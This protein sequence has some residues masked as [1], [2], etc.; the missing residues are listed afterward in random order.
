MKYLGISSNIFGINI[1]KDINKK[2]LFLSQETQL[3]K[4]LDMFGILKTKLV[5]LP[6]SQLFKLRHDQ[7]PS[8]IPQNLSSI[9]L[10]FS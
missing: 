4:V 1:K 6:I 3:K 8:V 5:T 10:P 2:A 7:A 9:F